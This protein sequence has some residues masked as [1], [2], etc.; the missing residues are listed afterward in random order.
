MLHH[1]H[2]WNP[3]S[4]PVL[5]YLRPAQNIPDNSLHHVMLGNLSTLDSIPPMI[6]GGRP[7]TQQVSSTHLNMNVYLTILL[8]SCG[9]PFS[10]SRSVMAKRV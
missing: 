3:Y 9:L 8:F 1:G 10:P 2:D 6:Q 5:T 4:L 7:L